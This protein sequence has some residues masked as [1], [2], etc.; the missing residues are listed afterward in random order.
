VRINIVKEGN[1]GANTPVEITG[2][3]RDCEECKSVI[4]ELLQNTSFG[5]GGGG[6]GYGGGGYNGGGG[7]GY[8]DDNGYGNRGYG[9]GRSGGR[10]SA[11]FNCQQEGHMARDCPQGGGGGR[12]DRY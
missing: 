10:S 11:C 3:I 12:N 4:L 5:S 7:G 1:D 2:D 6:G 9:G 8:R